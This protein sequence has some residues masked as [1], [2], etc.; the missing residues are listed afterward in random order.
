MGSN[1]P[2]CKT[3]EQLCWIDVDIGVGGSYH[4]QLTI[5]VV[6]VVPA[7]RRNLKFLRVLERTS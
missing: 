7:N 6:L 3:M 5:F 4:R 2:N 1:E